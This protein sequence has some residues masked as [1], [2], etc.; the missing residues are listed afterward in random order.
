MNSGPMACEIFR[1]RMKLQRLNNLVQNDKPGLTHETDD[2]LVKYKLKATVK[3]VYIF[4]K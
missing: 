4:S 1:T 2:L 3:V